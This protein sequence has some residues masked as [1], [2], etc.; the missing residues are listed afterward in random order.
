L[1]IQDLLQLARVESGQTTFSI[2][3]VA[4]NEVC[5]TCFEQ[6]S[7]TATDRNLDLQLELA[8]PGPISRSDAE[9]IETIVDNLVDCR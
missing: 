9:S 7:E 3:D 1:Q 4:I 8:E 5:Q 2:T 6:F